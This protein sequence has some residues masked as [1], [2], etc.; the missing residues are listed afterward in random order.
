MKR[1]FYFDD[2]ERDLLRVALKFLSERIEGGLNVPSAHIKCGEFAQRRIT[3]MLARL[4]ES[5]TP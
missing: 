5:P 3:E 2:V 4:Q 1:Q